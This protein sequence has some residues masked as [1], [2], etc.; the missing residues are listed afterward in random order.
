MV[1]TMGDDGKVEEKEWSE[2]REERGT[3]EKEA[4][5]YCFEAVGAHVRTVISTVTRRGLR[6]V[7]GM[8]SSKR[9]KDGKH[10]DRPKLS[11]KL[12]INLVGK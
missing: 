11:Y 7:A 1:R 5:V 6:K 12:T 2:L 3:G 10:F 8:C 9:A 4:I